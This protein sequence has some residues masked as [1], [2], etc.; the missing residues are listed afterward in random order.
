[1]FLIRVTECHAYVKKWLSNCTELLE[2][3]PAE[4][5]ETKFPL[6]FD[7]DDTIKTLGMY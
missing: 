7:H 2:N 3:V 4:H 6:R 5:R 1:M